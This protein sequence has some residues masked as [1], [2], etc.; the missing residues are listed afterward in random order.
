MTIWKEV[1]VFSGQNAEIAAG[2]TANEIFAN[3]E[4]YIQ[5]RQKYGSY[6]RLLVMNNS[7]EDIKVTLDTTDLT[8]LIPGASVSIDPEEGIRWELLKLT[9]L[10]AANAAGANEISVRQSTAIPITKT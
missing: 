7:T 3:T 9:N 5:S 1:N 6:N 8:I 10:D 2:G 4:A